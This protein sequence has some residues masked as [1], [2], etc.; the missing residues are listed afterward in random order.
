MFKT[1]AEY[2]EAWENSEKITPSIPLNVDIELACACNLRCPFCYVT[3]PTFKQFIKQ[4]LQ[5]F[6]PTPRALRI[7]DACSKLGAPSLKF[8][9][10]GEATL[11]KYFST[12]VLYAKSK[13]TF[14]DLMV[15]TNGNFPK[16]SVPGLMAATKVMVSV[17]SLIPETYK[18]MRVRGDLVLVRD[19]VFR[20]LSLG[21]KNLW[22]RRVLSSVNKDEDFAGEARRLFGPAI[23]IS[24]HSEF[25]RTSPGKGLKDDDGVCPV[26][27][28]YCGYPSQRLTIATNGNVY[29]C[30]VDIRETMSLGNVDAEDLLCMWNGEK[31]SLLRETLKQGQAMNNACA[32]CE[33]WMAYES[34]K[35]QFVGDKEIK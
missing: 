34:D 13:N 29:P 22:V 30:C 11:H 17:D 8:N 24:E 32:N 16:G 20:L 4:E 28:R 7:I 10:R 35:R 14:F 3:E 2:R 21:H 26:A 1:F 9:W 25:D 15:N 23:H 19:N 31:M 5:R 33:S 6:M 12:I 27:R 18:A